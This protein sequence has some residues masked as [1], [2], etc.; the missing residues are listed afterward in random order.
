[1]N[2]LNGATHAVFAPGSIGNVGPGFD[3]LG[4]AVEELGDTA[5]LDRLLRAS[6]LGE[7]AATGSRHLDN[8]APCILGG[9]A[10][11]RSNSPMDIMGLPVG[12]DWWVALVSP[13]LRIETRTARQLLPEEW[14]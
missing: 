14:D 1:M 9:L 5:Q 4:L 7:E 10:L 8:L 11:V 3:T 2:P 13:A 6:A 12:A